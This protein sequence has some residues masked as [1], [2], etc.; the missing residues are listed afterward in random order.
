MKKIVLL[1]TVGAGAFILG[2]CSSEPSADQTN[3]STDVS[4]TE[5][6]EQYVEPSD[7]NL[8]EP[9]ASPQPFALGDYT[10][11]TSVI[12]GAECQEGVICMNLEQY[13]AMCNNVTAVSR[14]MT[15]SWYLFGYAD[16]EVKALLEAGGNIDSIRSQWDA[17]E[18][19][20]RV[21]VD[22]SG[23]YEG[24]S[25]AG[26][27]ET[28]ARDFTVDDEGDTVVTAGKISTVSL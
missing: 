17:S 1:A 26:Y 9:A 6:R 23:V 15:K 22:V 7:S 25:T 20:C 5:S 19:A 27:A 8:S 21:Y 16:E 13:E 4:D 11:N 28:W 3:S 24:T 10:Y 12:R 2:G 18:G 14:S